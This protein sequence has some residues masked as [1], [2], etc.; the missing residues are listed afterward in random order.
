[1]ATN[2]NNIHINSFSKGM[3]TDTSL[4]MVGN[5]QYVFGQNIRITA[6]S[7]LKGAIDSNSKEGIVTPVTSGQLGHGSF[8]VNNYSIL[9]IATVGD[10]GAIIVKN[11]DTTWSIYRI[12]YK[13]DSLSFTNIFNSDETTSKDKFSVVINKETDNLVKLY[14]ADGKD[15]IMQINIKDNVETN[16]QL[17]AKDLRRNA[18]FPKRII[19]IGE[20]ISGTLRTGQVQYTYRLYH[21]NGICS[22]LAP[23]TN[24]IHVIDSSRDK[25]IGNAE[26][27][28]TTVGFQLIV[29]LIDSEVEN[30]F[31]HIQIY[32]LE[33]VKP[34]SDAEVFLIYDSKITNFNTIKINDNGI[35]PIQ[36]LSIQEFASLDTIDIT[37]QCIE[38]NQNY[39]FA[40][41][42][43]DKTLLKVGNKGLDFDSKAYQFAQ[44]G[45]IYL[46][47]NNDTTYKFRQQFDSIDDV[48]QQ[49]DS[50]EGSKWSLNSYSDMTVDQ[51]NYLSS[52]LC[53]Y[54]ENNYLGGT[55]KNVSWRFITTRIPLDTIDEDSKELPP[56][57]ENSSNQMVNY[58]KYDNGQ[59]VEEYSG[60]GTSTIL[61]QHG[62]KTNCNLSYSDL[63]T[64]S[65]FRSLR[66]DETYRYG[67]VLYDNN[68]RRSDV[69]WIGDIRTPSESEFS[70]TCKDE[71]KI[72]VSDST[73]YHPCMCGEAVCGESI[74]GGTNETIHSSVVVPA[75][76]SQDTGISST[77][78][79]GNLEYNPL[80]RPFDSTIRT[81]EQNISQAV[82]KQ[83]QTFTSTTNSTASAQLDP[84]S[85]CSCDIRISS[86][87]NPQ[88]M[89]FYERVIEINNV[90]V[91][92]FEQELQAKI[93]QLCGAGQ[94]IIEN[95]SMSID[96]YMDWD[97]DR[98]VAK[99]K[100]LNIHI[101]L[102]SNKWFK[103]IVVKHAVLRAKVNVN[104]TNTIEDTHQSSNRL[105]ARPI[106]IQFNVH[107]LPEGI[108]AYQIVRCAKTPQYTK[109]IMQCA[110]SRPVR[111]QM[112][113]SD[114]DNVTMRTSPYYPTPFLTSDYMRVA[115]NPKH[116]IDDGEFGGYEHQKMFTATNEDN[117]ELF[118]IFS[119]E[120]QVV[121]QDA[122]AN[123]QSYVLKMSPVYFAYCESAS[124]TN[125]RLYGGY[126]NG[127]YDH[128]IMPE[129]PY[130]QYVIEQC[131]DDSFYF[132][133]SRVKGAD[134]VNSDSN[135]LRH[136]KDELSFVF[137]YYDK[138][139]YNTCKPKQIQD[140]KNVSNPTWDQA[141]SNIQL[142][143]YTVLSGVKQYKS[144]STSINKFE[145][146]NWVCNGMYDL[147][148]SENMSVSGY[149][150]YG[151]RI[152]AAIL[153]YDK[154]GDYRDDRA[155]GW[156]GP[157]PR[158]FLA[159]INNT[160]Q[161]EDYKLF[162]SGL[163]FDGTHDK[164]MTCVVNVQH[165]P[166]QYSGLTDEEKQ[167]DVY[168]GFGNTNTNVY[169]A[170]NVFDGDVYITPCEITTMYKAY[171][172]N[173]YDTLPS[174]QFI[175]YIPLEST[176]NTYLDYGMGYR[177]T[178]SKC[179]MI[180]PGEITG[181]K[182]QARPEHQYNTIYSDNN[183]SNDI[184]VAQSLEDSEQK[185][186]QRIHY[187]VLKTNGE[188][189]DNWQM[190]KALDYIDVDTRYGQIT[191]LLTNKDIIYFWQNQA[192]GKLSVNERSLVTDNN[193]NTIQ[194][195]QGGV[196]QRSDYINTR[197]G[198]R[199]QDYSAISAEGAIYWIDIINK[200]ILMSNGQSVMNLGEQLNVQ[201]CINK[202]IVDDIPTIHYDLQNNELL[203]K[204]LEYGK[205]IVFNIKLNIATSIYDRKY[206][207]SIVFDNVLFGILGNQIRKYNYIQGEPQYDKITSTIKFVVNSAPSTT[208][209]FDNQEIVTLARGEEP[210][211]Y[212]DGKEFA[213]T[214][215]TINETKKNPV[216]YTDR[217]G[218]V[219]YAIPRYDGEYGHRMRGK[220]MQVDIEDSKPKYEHSISHILTKFRQSFS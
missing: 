89:M 207:D 67:I 66:R 24:K 51:S 129:T 42:I 199:L 13:D 194:L 92:R 35:D 163:R 217:E 149:G 31:D 29:N 123:L 98:R 28:Q 141:F 202:L 104:I 203:C 210:S 127:M 165:V 32:R 38:Q 78:D 25:E 189:I 94:C 49:N 117:T 144:F 12:D 110:I 136:E 70:S 21:K 97:G 22:K 64:S 19:D 23:L 211:D 146:D 205:Q 160:D 190:F 161:N 183:I 61:E 182:T 76:N 156:I 54:D 150:N 128:S 212:F 109:N 143:G 215:N 44:D 112:F 187:S 148:V 36:Q 27:T 176:I 121:Q 10:I 119:P 15:G 82:N 153:E 152:C 4:D 99:I 53:K 145:Y 9:A 77:W 88:D 68:G 100:K 16:L 46:Y 96:S 157:G 122:L 115:W 213:F 80:Y 139:F 132:I 87:A 214:T 95:A 191:N 137:K 91:G 147:R 33:Y 26:D 79:V 71:D 116:H 126:S 140:I 85:L 192:F 195:G 174:A 220:W 37:P 47:K 135:L 218:N 63:F 48:I 196:L 108:S 81:N 201:N 169:D 18:Y 6:N 179:V 173:S 204:C 138:E 208:K 40:A 65:M 41:N 177:N 52:D 90:P 39:M 155:R 93:D 181:I 105:Y 164:I 50:I 17:K 107:N 74:V 188:L 118:Q 58:L 111:Q 101:K 83:S 59:I 72:I 184:Y 151:D 178:K 158:C 200:A 20:K 134:Y 43:E 30:V 171:E 102:N 216:G 131:G 1:M 180:E 73:I 206:E 124:D 142:N 130:Q 172:F 56:F 60:L 159:S 120:I 106:G 209:V 75:Y 198:M 69:Q 113:R 11:Q 84:S 114:V 7:L 154:R 2:Q 197:Y 57:I 5:E 170:Y 62:I 133:R 55:G 86:L 125:E 103:F 193:S 219:R 45:K 14:I 167:Y 168:Y 185:F 34:H 186:S 162:A 3:N 166:S 175:Y 8:D